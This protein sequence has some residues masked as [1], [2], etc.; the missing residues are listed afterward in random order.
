[1][2]V[3]LRFGGPDFVRQAIKNTESV[4]VPILKEFGFYVGRE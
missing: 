2:G 1:L 3:E 4:G